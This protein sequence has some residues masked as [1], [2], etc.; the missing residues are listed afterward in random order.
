MYHGR[1][2]GTHYNVGYKWGELL[3][4]NNKISNSHLVI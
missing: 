2:K 4:K 1:F 3:Y